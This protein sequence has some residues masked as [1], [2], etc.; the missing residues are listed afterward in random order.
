MNLQALKFQH[1]QIAKKLLH[2]HVQKKFAMQK[3]QM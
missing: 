1:N 2:V 3:F